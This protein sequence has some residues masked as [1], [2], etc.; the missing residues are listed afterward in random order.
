MSSM[1][2]R[3]MNMPNVSAASGT[4]M[5]KSSAASTRRKNPRCICAPDSALGYNALSNVAAASFSRCPRSI[6]RVTRRFTKKCS[7]TG[8]SNFSTLIHASSMSAELKYSLMIVSAL[9]LY[10]T[11]TSDFAS[12]AAARNPNGSSVES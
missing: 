12:P 11:T 10:S 3:A 5:D 7:Y 8:A 1:M 9:F 6:A 2:A 4:S